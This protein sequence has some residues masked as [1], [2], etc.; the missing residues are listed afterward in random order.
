MKLYEAGVPETADSS[1]VLAASS[2]LTNATH[3]SAGNILVKH[4]SWPA[5]RASGT[6]AVTE[7]FVRGRVW[8]ALEALVHRVGLGV[9]TMVELYTRPRKLV[10]TTISIAQGRLVLVPEATSLKILD[11]DA[12][13]PESS[14]PSGLWEVVVENPPAG[15]GSR[16]F[17]AGGGNDSVSAFWSVEMVDKEEEANMEVLWYQVSS[18]S[19]ADPVSDDPRGML[20]SSGRAASIESQPAAPTEVFSKAAGFGLV[21]TTVF[22]KASGTALPKAALT[23]KAAPPKA[24]AP[25]ASGGP[26]ERKRLASLVLAGASDEPFDRK[27]FIPVFVNKVALAE[28]AEIK[29]LGS[30][31][32]A[33]PKIPKAISVVQLAKR[34]KA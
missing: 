3:C 27:V 31:E 17:L 7:A 9:D 4:P 8:C 32:K 6:S 16:V 12:L 22:S 21:P 30:A 33:P 5:K 19:G 26:T 34:A 29:V 28:G 10:K 25:P 13:S 1:M 11:K 18:L 23:P 14:A 24:R 2:F 20:V 15:F